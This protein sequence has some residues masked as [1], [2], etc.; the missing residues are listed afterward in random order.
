MWA[1]PAPRTKSTFVIVFLATLMSFTPLNKIGDFGFISLR[2]SSGGDGP[3]QSTFERSTVMQR[4]G[5]DGLAIRRDGTG[6]ESFSMIA[7]RDCLSVA[8]SQTLFVAYKALENQSP[9]VL[10]YNG[11]SRG[12]FFVRRVELV[13]ERGISVGAGGFHG[14][15]ARIM[16]TVQWELIAENA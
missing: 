14:S 8:A 11:T 16:Q 2:R 7:S 9:V 6:V 10:T 15:L 13:D 1:F 3:P 5:V 4:P 12:R